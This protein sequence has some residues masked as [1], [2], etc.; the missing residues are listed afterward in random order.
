VELQ[1]GKLALE[2]KLNEGS[3]FYFTL[4]FLKSSRHHVPWEES[5]QAEFHSLKGLKVLVAEDNLV[6]QKIVAKIL[7]KWDASPDLAENG[8]IAVEKV[9]KNHYNLVLMDINMPEM[10]GYEATMTIRNMQGEYF[11]DLPILAVT[12]TALSEDRNKF[13]SYGMNGY[14][15][16][17]FTPPQLYNKISHYLR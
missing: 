13:L 2:S 3:T 8:M 9:R 7:S 5:V 15:I 12:A 14:I 11:R 17:P 4:K 6:N 16:K 1:G 10:N